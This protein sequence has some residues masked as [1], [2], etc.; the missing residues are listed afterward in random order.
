M[1]TASGCAGRPSCAAALSSQSIRRRP[2]ATTISSRR[3]GSSA[4]M[5]ACLAVDSASLPASMCYVRLAAVFQ[6]RQR[7]GENAVQDA[8]LLRQEGRRRSRSPHAAE[9]VRPGPPAPLVLP[10]CPPRPAMHT[11]VCV[12]SNFRVATLIQPVH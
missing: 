2:P 1:R 5:A 11:L 4:K 3:A 10:S 6:P 8:H 12:Q 7:P 9:R